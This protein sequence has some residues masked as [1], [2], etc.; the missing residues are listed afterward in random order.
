MN[1][2]RHFIINLTVMEKSKGS[3]IPIV[4]HKK[5]NGRR[6]RIAPQLIDFM[7]KHEIILTEDI[8]LTKS[9]LGRTLT[10]DLEKM[11]WKR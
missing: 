9:L 6:G 8:P 4:V 11:D 2:G 10:S 5:F 3:T 1:Y 7:L